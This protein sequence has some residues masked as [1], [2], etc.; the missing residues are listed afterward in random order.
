M[1]QRL[2][3]VISKHRKTYRVVQLVRTTGNAR[4]LRVRCDRQRVIFLSAIV[5]SMGGVYHSS[6]VTKVLTEYVVLANILSKRLF[7]ARRTEEA[8]PHLRR[9]IKFFKKSGRLVFS[10]NQASEMLTEKLR[11]SDYTLEDVSY[12][13][14]MKSPHVCV[15]ELSHK[16]SHFY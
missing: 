6:E 5:D 8:L 11:G 14:E 3:S 13:G 7:D 1:S 16:S 12:V 10:G 4:H 2:I 15:F 9:R